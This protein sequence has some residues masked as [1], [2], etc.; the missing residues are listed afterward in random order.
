MNQSAQILWERLHTMGYTGANITDAGYAY[1]AV[2][3]IALALNSSNQ[4]L[5]KAGSGLENF[6]Y[7]DG[8]AAQTFKSELL[9]TKFV[10]VTVM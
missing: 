2:L 5:H 10:G 4:R 3:A 7:T 6:T 8:R 9:N 1:D